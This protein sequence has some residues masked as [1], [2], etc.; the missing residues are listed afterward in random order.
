M[1]LEGVIGER[2]LL[3]AH[4]HRDS[5]LVAGLGQRADVVVRVAREKEDVERPVH[6]DS[7]DL[8]PE[9]RRVRGALVLEPGRRE[10]LHSVLHCGRK[11][12]VC[13]IAEPPI[14][15]D[16]PGEAIA[17]GPHERVPVLFGEV[18]ERDDP[19]RFK[20]LLKAAEAQ[21]R[22]REERLRFMAGF[23]ESPSGSAE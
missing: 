6:I 14:R 17:S 8:P 21:S 23:Q 7:R 10:G 16:T 11:Q 4:E 3:L 22:L 20:A 15:N 13:G 5:E 1:G 19:A 2:R 9:P 12:A 18:V